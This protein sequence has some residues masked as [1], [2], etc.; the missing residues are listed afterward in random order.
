MVTRGV[1]KMPKQVPSSQFLIY[2]TDSGQTK[3]DVRFEEETVW[4]TQALLA[5]LFQVTIPTVNE[6]LKNIFEEEECNRDATIRKFLIVRQEGPRSV[7]REIEH[8][9]LDV[10]LPANRIWD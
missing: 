3:I 7:S 5:E 8:Y 1:S 4:L 10:I 6:H 9:N 2:Q